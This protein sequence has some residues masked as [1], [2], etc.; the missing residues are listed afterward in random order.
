MEHAKNPVKRYERRKILQLSSVEDK[1]SMVL[2]SWVVAA[3]ATLL[4]RGMDRQTESCLV[5]RP[6]DV[7]VRRA[8]ISL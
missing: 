3:V 1:Q 5:N 7:S 8:L 4:H 2:P 6:Q